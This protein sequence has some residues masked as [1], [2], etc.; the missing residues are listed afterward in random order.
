MKAEIQNLCAI[1]GVFSFPPPP[2]LICLNEDRTSSANKHDCCVTQL[3][4][5]ERKKKN[6]LLIKYSSP[7]EISTGLMAFYSVIHE[8][9]IFL[10]DH[11]EEQM[12]S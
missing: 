6:D 7:Y 1:S 12:R 3:C 4:V 9:I 5:L 8:M 11:K 2:P 10:R